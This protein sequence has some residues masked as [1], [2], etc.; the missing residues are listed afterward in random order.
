MKIS[1]GARSSPLSRAQVT[2]VLTELRQYYPEIAF[3]TTLVT[4]TGD[5]DQKT[6]LRTLD[7]TD[8]FTKEIDHLLLNRECRIGVHSAKDLPDPIPDGLSIIAVTEGVDSSDSLVLPPGCTLKPGDTIATSSERREES[9]RQLCSDLNF[10]DIRGTIGQR[11]EKLNDGKIQGVVIAEA[12]LIRLGWTHLNRI[13]LPGTTTPGQGQL[14]VLAR[15]NDQEIQDFFECIDS[16]KKCL[17]LGL[18]IPQNT[19]TTRYVHCPII[20]IVPRK[21]ETYPEI[22]SFTHV[23]FTSKTSVKIFFDHFKELNDK[24]ILSVGKKTTQKLLSLG[25]PSLSLQK[26]NVRKGSSQC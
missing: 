11:L 16:R 24:I 7:K 19:L 15:K 8:F 20:K 1:V 14:A 17:Y 10:V 2:E 9:V 6:S 4:T 26:M 18:D 12:A 22:A 23:I 3:E 13:T 5:H 21:I 25:I